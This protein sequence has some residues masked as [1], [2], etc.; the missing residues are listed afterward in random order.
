MHVLNTLYYLILTRSVR[1]LL[2]TGGKIMTI[3]FFRFFDDEPIC[4]SDDVMIE[5]T[6]TLT[7]L[8]IGAGKRWH[9]GEF[10]YD[11]CIWSPA[12]AANNN[13]YFF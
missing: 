11:P 3:R 8:R 1:E 7:S 10:R 2:Y 12:T 6:E 9:C 4:P 13:V 5:N